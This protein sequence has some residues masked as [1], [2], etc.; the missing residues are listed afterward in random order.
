MKEVTRIFFDPVPG[1]FTE[2]PEKDGSF[3]TLVDVTLFAGNGLVALRH[4]ALCVKDFALKFI[5]DL[6]IYMIYMRE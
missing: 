1:L 4:I 6:T 2:G 5:E 3:F